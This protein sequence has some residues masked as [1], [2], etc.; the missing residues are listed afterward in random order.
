MYRKTYVEIDTN[1]LK[2]NVDKIIRHYKGYKCYMGIVKG[3]AYG[4]S[5]LICE[6]IIESGI[7]YLGVSSLEEALRIRKRIKSIPILSLEPVDIS[8]LGEVIKNNITI[9]VHDVNYFEEILSSKLDGLLKFHLKIDSGLNRLGLKEKKDIEYIVDAA[10]KNTHMLLEGIYTHM[11]TSGMYDFHYDKQMSCFKELIKDVDLTKIPYIHGPRSLTLMS[12]EKESVFNTAR[13]G[14]MMY[15]YNNL[16][17]IPNT[18][19]GRLRK[20]KINMMKKRL[21]VSETITKVPFELKSA[22][23]LYSEIITVKKVKKGEYIGYG[24]LYQAKKDMIIGIMPIGY[25]DGL[26]KKCVGLNVLINNK[27]YKIIGNIYMDMTTIEIDENVK[28]HD[29]VTIIGDTMNAKKMSSYFGGT[30]YD[31]LVGISSRVPRVIIKNGEIVNIKEM[32]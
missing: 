6:H 19:K 20:F 21:N 25:A 29:K 15:G 17:T 10:N 5:D 7:N 16:P 23:S 18:L 27:P 13:I 32:K 11:A 2:E 4:H 12:H 26:N 14:I 31:V 28:T 1:I 24:A 30:V 3:D 9:T 8:S 22:Y